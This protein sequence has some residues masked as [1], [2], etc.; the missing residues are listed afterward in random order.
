MFTFEQPHDHLDLVIQRVTLNFRFCADDYDDVLSMG[1]KQ[2]SM[3][4]LGINTVYMCIPLPQCM[5]LCHLFYPFQVLT[6][7]WTTNKNRFPKRPKM[8]KEFSFTYVHGLFS[9]ILDHCGVFYRNKCNSWEKLCQQ[10]RQQCPM[11]YVKY[12][13]SWLIFARCRNYFWKFNVTL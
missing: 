3:F 12:L 9:C 10:F 13:N 6:M 2:K 4:L 1:N 11:L 7:D 5:F 8:K